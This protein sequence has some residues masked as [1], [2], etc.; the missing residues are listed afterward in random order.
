MQQGAV[1]NAEYVYRFR[2]HLT[3]ERPLIKPLPAGIDV[4]ELFEVGLP[5]QG[6]PRAGVLLEPATAVRNVPELPIEHRDRHRG[7][8]HDLAEVLLLA[9]P[10][11][12]GQHS[13]G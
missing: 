3:G 10:L 6:T 13:L 2:K 11:A 4:R 1:R 7:V 8:S 12:L 5:V 9:L